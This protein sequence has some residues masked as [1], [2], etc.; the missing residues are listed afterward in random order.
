[1]MMMSHTCRF[2]SYVL[3]CILRSAC[4]FVH[5]IRVV[6]MLSEI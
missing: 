1:M 6:H 2:A 4:L 3:Y 5:V